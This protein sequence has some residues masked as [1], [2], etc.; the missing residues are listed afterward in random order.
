MYNIGTG[1]VCTRD[2]FKI[3]PIPDVVI[4]L[5]TDKA[6][7]Q[8]FRRGVMD[9]GSNIHQAD[10]L[11]NGMGIDQEIVD[12]RSQQA[13]SIVDIA[14]VTDNTIRETVREFRNDF[15]DDATPGLDDDE[16]ADA[17]DVLDIP[18][19]VATTVASPAVPSPVFPNVIDAG[20]QTFNLSSWDQ[21]TDASIKN[22]WSEIQ[23]IGT[24]QF[25]INEH[26]CTET[27]NIVLFSMLVN[28]VIIL[29]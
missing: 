27:Q 16:D 9:Q 2:Q 1:S 10:Q 6:T 29:I 12:M 19:D 5:L 14:G 4:T 17:E 13:D 22:N 11:P 15:A 18:T 24:V 8:G 28:I 26:V 3:L 25:I 7:E 21:I 23:N 20:L